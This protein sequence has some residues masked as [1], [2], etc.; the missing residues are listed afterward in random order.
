ML[1]RGRAILCKLYAM[2][3]NST[4][5]HNGFQS[6]IMDFKIIIYNFNTIL[7]FK[8]IIYNTSLI[9]GG[10][11]ANIIFILQYFFTI[12]G[13]GGQFFAFNLQSAIYNI[14]LWI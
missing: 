13:G 1:G 5:Y 4:I 11:E 3:L 8:I 14:Q 7:D 9:L 12:L 10:R 6:T 2:I